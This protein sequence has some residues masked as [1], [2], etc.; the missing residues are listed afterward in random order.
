MS[1]FYSADTLKTIH[2]RI[3]LELKSGVI[4]NPGFVERTACSGSVEKE[5]AYQC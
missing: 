2:A 4:N 1:K 5:T 3:K